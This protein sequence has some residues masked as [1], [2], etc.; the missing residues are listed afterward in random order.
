MVS[1][2]IYINSVTIISFSEVPVHIFKLVNAKFPNI[3]WY[4]SKYFL[5]V[6]GNIFSV[7]SYMPFMCVFCKKSYKY[8]VKSGVRYLGLMNTINLYQKSWELCNFLRCKGKCRISMLDTHL[9]RTTHI[10]IYATHHSMQYYYVK[11]HEY[12]SQISL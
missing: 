11:D 9:V 7:L 3:I 1:Q 6:L 12:K 8:P 5:N 4:R 10:Y 2:L